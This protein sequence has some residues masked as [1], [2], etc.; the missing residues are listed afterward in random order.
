M[1]YFEWLRVGTRVRSVTILGSVFF[2]LSARL[3]NF[4]C[5]E[6]Q[7]MKGVVLVF[8][9]F[10]TSGTFFRINV[11]RANALQNFPSFVRDPN[12]AF[13]KA[14]NRRYLRIR[15]FMDKLSRANGTKFFRAS[16]LWRRLTF[17]MNI[18]FN[19][20]TFS[21]NHCSRCFDSFIFCNFTSDVRVFVAISYTYFVCIA[22]VRCQFINRRR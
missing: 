5:D 13:I 15:R 8:S 11:S 14:N 21:L 2:S 6:F 1:F 12:A 10:N 9:S 22:S 4:F 17:F 20:L 7:A 3:S 16:L 18:R 19:G